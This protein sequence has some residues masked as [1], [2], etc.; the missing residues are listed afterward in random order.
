M[1]VAGGL[2]LLRGSMLSRDEANALPLTN[3]L[4]AN[5]V[6]VDGMQY[7]VP[8]GDIYDAGV[9]ADSIPALTNPRSR[10][11]RAWTVY[12]PTR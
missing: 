3:G 9:A 5:A 7:L 4:F 1:V 2:F 6:T 11:S 10:T 8:P 12:L